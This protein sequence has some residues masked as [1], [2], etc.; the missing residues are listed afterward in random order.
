MDTMTFSSLQSMQEL[1]KEALS[2]SNEWQTIDGLVAICDEAG[3]WGTGFAHRAIAN[4]KK[5]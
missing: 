4:A 1:V 3:C 5:S 2:N